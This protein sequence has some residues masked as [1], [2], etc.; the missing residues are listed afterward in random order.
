MNPIEKMTNNDSKKPESKDQGSKKSNSRD[1]NSRASKKRNSTSRQNSKDAQNNTLSP[2]SM[3]GGRK[4]GYFSKCTDFNEV[5]EIEY[6]TK[7]H[8]KLPKA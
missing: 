5:K 3:S 6:P 4:T 7:V 2:S 8:P 1:L